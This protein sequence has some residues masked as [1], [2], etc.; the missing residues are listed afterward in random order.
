MSEDAPP[1]PTPVD[2]AVLALSAADAK[3]VER[4]AF[5]RRDAAVVAAVRA[6]ARLDE[7]ALAAGVTKAAVSAI[8]RKTLAPRSARGGPYRRRRG[9]EA[10]VAVIRDASELAA[11]ATQDRRLAVGE[12]DAAI[13]SAFGEGLPIGSIARAVGMEP[14]VLHNLIRRRRAE[15]TQEPFGTLASPKANEEHADTIG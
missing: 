2:L 10:A 3:G 5:Q 11:T 8:A 7:I 1:S 4:E 9:V 13:V 14:K 12:R 15:A 6:G